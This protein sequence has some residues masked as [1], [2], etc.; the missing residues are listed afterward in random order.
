M[1]LAP[2]SIYVVGR[3]IADPSD[4]G[5]YYVRAYVFDA[6]TFSLLETL[7]LTDQGN[8][9]HTKEYRLP[10][11][12][13]GAGRQL[14]IKTTVFTDAGHTTKSESYSEEL[15]TELLVKVTTSGNGGGYSGGADIDYTKIEKIVSTILESHHK[16]MMDSM[17]KNKPEPLEMSQI[18]DCLKTTQGAIIS[19]IVDNKAKEPEEINLRPVLSEI[20]ASEKRITYVNNENLDKTVLSI[21]KNRELLS[22]D[23]KNT[24]TSIVDNITGIGKM[25]VIMSKQIASFFQ[26]K[27]E[28][29]GKMAKLKRVINEMV[30]SEDEDIDLEK[31]KNLIE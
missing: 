14:L 21:Q 4:I 10:A 7:D 16:K 12:P 19:A 25:M 22:T 11:D 3:H 31:I 9:T 1:Q 18:T 24:E 8:G 17:E 2:Q 26:S 5:T 20:Q 30:D 27:L 13:S 28:E 15:E 29:K 6:R 23:F